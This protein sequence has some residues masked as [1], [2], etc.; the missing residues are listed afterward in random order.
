VS[1]FLAA[2]ALL[3]ALGPTPAT[4]TDE[5]RQFRGGL[6]DGMHF[7]T[8]RDAGGNERVT[9]LPA[10]PNASP[11]GAEVARSVVGLL[12]AFR[13]AAHFTPVV[14]QNARLYLDGPGC[15]LPSDIGD[16]PI[17][18]ASA[19]EK[20]RFDDVC[21]PSAPYRLADGAVRIEWS[22]NGNLSYVAWFVFSGRKVSSGEV[23]DAVAPNLMRSRG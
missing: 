9:L 16:E 3:S 1:A 2:A 6:Y 7:R 11:P 5:V 15:R 23:R 10:A 4:G 17:C 8:T 18:K 12:A 21:V 14:A 22:C 13:G 20:L 19:F